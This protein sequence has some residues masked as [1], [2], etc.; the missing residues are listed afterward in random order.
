M[1]LATP[2]RQLHGVGP[3]RAQILSRLGLVN[4]GDLIRHLPLR[5]ERLLAEGAI[6]D[7]PMQGI[8]SARGTVVNTRI[9]GAGGP[10]RRNAGRFQATLQD[11]SNTL[12]LVWFHG[13]FLQQK[14]HPGMVLRVQGKVGAYQGYPQMV[15]PEWEVLDEDAPAAALGERL[16]PIYSATEDLSSAVIEEL[17]AQ[18]LPQVVPLLIDPLPEELVKARAMPVLADAYR[19]MHQPADEAEAAAARRR[20]A[21]NEL[22]LLQLG[23]SLKRHYNQTR[24]EAP[25]LRWS[26]AMDQ[27]IRDRFPF[28]LTG[29][30]D[31]VVAEIV[32]DL[33]QGR[34]MNRLLQGDVG[35]GKT[36][37]ALYALLL[38]VADRKQ[39]AIMAPTELLAE[40]HFLSISRM[41]QG[42]SVRLLLLTS[43]QA[44]ARTA[45]RA[46]ILRQ[47]ES[48]EADII[49]GTQALLTESVHFKDLAVVVVDEQHRFGVMQRAVLRERAGESETPI[50]P[51][52]RLPAA[53]CLVMTATPI[54]RTLSLT[55]FGDLD[56]STI[57]GLP[58]GRTPI[59]TKVVGQTKA[60][61]VYRYIATLVAKGRQAYVV[62]PTIDAG[63]EESAAQLKNLRAHAELLRQRYFAGAQ[64][65]EMHGRLKRQTRAAIMERF[66]EGQIRVLVAT[67]VIEVGVD[68]PNATVMVV[69]HA[70]RF[71]LAQLHQLRGRVGRSSDGTRSLCVFIAEPKTEDAQR[72]LDALAASQDGF[73]IAEQDLAIRGMGEFFGT[74]QHGQ[75]PLRMAH[76]PE[77]MD[78]LKL[79][80]HDAQAIVQAD[81]TLSQACH[82]RLHKVLVRQY[83]DAL[84][85]IDVG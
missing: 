12:S 25:A 72:R 26:G 69:E 76:I 24:L 27:H 9:A 36:V 55:V 32:D 35:S 11:H 59:T 30:Q 85:L 16:R 73:K 39:G 56:V 8:G 45:T 28:A 18:V 57:D 47:I 21:F 17:V 75:A 4:V 79:A 65:A 53:H 61:E 68:V 70:E 51:N 1:A 41:L 5:H 77:D 29:A 22:L 15:N 40:Q 14:I 20:L 78:L 66:R 7:L 81:P 50:A 71:G 19:M 33:R 38:A 13:G 34:P 58:P 37:V 43:G 49:V 83:G 80:R 62:V 6:G 10:F 42:A 3:R 74:R 64:V 31:R 60:D 46:A 23:I 84:G 52:A 48:G 44:G 2:L 54:P 63:G 82:Q 67:T